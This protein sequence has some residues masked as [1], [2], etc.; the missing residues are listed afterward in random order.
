MSKRLAAG[1]VLYLL[2]C[3][4]GA[5]ASAGE[6]VRFLSASVPPSAFKMRLAKE[7]GQTAMAEPA[8][9]IAGNLYRPAGSGPFPAVVVL[10]GCAGP[11]KPDAQSETADWFNAMGYVAL[12]VDSFGP[13][14]IQHN[15]NGASSADRTMDAFG[16]LDY[17]A[18]QSFVRPDRIAVVGASLGGG[19]ALYAVALDAPRTAP[20]HR[21]AAAVAYYPPCDSAN[22]YAP[23]LILIGE[24]DDWTPAAACRAM[25]GKR[26]GAGAAV[27]LVVYPS[28]HH[29]FNARRLAGNPQMFF[30]HRLEYNEAADL[31]ARDEVK[32]FLATMIG[33]P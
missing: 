10:H 20:D 3:S 33:R 6:A 24:L 21:F 26:T 17:L 16:A 31:A 22:V 5:W 12:F 27:R 9:E 14:G 19:T 13:R 28:A 29:D 1:V 32:Q 2:A 11:S 4:A 18:A 23:V 25:I 30:G 7:R 8:D 15:C